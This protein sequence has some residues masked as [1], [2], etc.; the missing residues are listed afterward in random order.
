[1]DGTYNAVVT[2]VSIT[3]RNGGHKELMATLDVS[4][5]PLSTT[6]GAWI[7]DEYNPATQEHVGT[8]WGMEYIRRVIATLEASS[9]ESIKGMPCRVVIENGLCTGLGHFY[10]DQWFF[11]QKDLQHLLDK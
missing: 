7:L 5:E 8:A 10:K 3:G 2:N 9:W 6:F 4:G 11:P 1:M